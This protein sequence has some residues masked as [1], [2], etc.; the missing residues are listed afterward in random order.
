MVLG[1]DTCVQNSQNQ[2]I[3]PETQNEFLQI[4]EL[5]VLRKV[6]G[7]LAGEYFTIM[8]DE[9]TDIS[10]SPLSSLCG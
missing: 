5:S 7:R 8:A 3:C 10:T 2:F 6:V 4:L 1:F 9:T